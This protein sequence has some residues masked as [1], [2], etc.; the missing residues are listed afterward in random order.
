V[1]G[2]RSIGPGSPFKSSK[3]NGGGHGITNPVT[4]AEW[5]IIVP[6]HSECDK[7]GEPEHHGHRIQSE[8]GKLVGEAREEGGCQRQVGQHQQGPDGDKD[9]EADLRGSVDGN[10]TVIIVEPVGRYGDDARVV[11][12]AGPWDA[13]GGVCETGGSRSMETYHSR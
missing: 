1:Q 3:D 13:I 8:N 5:E 11:S 4:R 6:I 10:E 12:T 9:H 7:A 2:W